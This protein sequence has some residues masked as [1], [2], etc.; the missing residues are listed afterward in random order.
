M[1]KYLV[2]TDDTMRYVKTAKEAALAG[3]FNDWDWAQAE[4]QINALKPGDELDLSGTNSVIRLS[5]VNTEFTR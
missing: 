1:A 5:G 2:I 3:G 4:R